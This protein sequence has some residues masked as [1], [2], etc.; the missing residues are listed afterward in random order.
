LRLTL[1]N[2][3][4]KENYLYFR[5]NLKIIS[6]K[7]ILL[8]LVAVYTSALSYAQ[9]ADGAHANDFTVTDQFGVQH[10]LYSYLDQGMTVILD[11]SATW[12]GPCWMYHQSGTLDELYMMHG[13]AGAPGVDAA[14]TNDV[15]VIWVDGDGSTTDAEVA[16][17]AG[18]QGNWL[19]NSATGLPLDYPVCNPIAA[20]ADAINADYAIGYFPTV[21]QICPDR[22]VIELDPAFNGT[23]FDNNAAEVYA[24]IACS[25]ATLAADVAFAS[26]YNGGTVSCG[27]IALGT[28]TIKNYGIDNLTSC[29]INVAGNALTAPININWTGDLATYQVAE[30]DLGTAALAQSGNITVT[31]TADAYPANSTMTQAVTK[32]TT[33]STTQVRVGI[34]FDDW[35]EEC[36]WGI[37]DEA[38]N[39]I[40]I[41]DYSVNTPAAGSSVAQLVA[42]PATGC[43]TFVYADAYN[44]GLH[45]SQWNPNTFGDGEMTVTTVNADNSTFSTIWAY[46]GSYDVSV[47][48]SAINATNTVA[49]VGVNEVAMTEE[50][51]SAYPNPTNNQTN[52]NFMITTASEVKMSVINMLGDVVMNNN[53]GTLAAGNY[54][55]VVNFS[56]MPAGL[57]LVNLNVNGKV[58]TLRLTVS[59]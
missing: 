53:F 25:S 36:I 38:G 31:V 14:T 11:I 40:T 17:G 4:A 5:R 10:N 51:L 59:K 16:G 27:S 35:P 6:M 42:L 41:V 26:Q 33:P 19:L 29:T 47:Q 45:G 46:D 50:V 34:T 58:S 55:E 44:D 43:Y 1:K 23:N 57:Y 28:L 18:S 24:G 37:F 54:N 32:V 9:L 48:E 8:M 22:S 39:A 49:T 7:K 30:V 2:E 21:Y 52:V 12:C 3:C 15:M 56:N 13:P 20:D